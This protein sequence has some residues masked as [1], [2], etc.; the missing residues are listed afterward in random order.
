LAHPYDDRGMDI[1][2]NN[3]QRLQELYRKYNKYLLK[4]NVD[5]MKKH[6]Q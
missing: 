2:G 4:C 5:E 6:Y 1:I 3:K